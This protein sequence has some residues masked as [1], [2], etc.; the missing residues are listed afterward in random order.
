MKTD[1]IDRLLDK[2]LPP[3]GP[4]IWDAARAE[5]AA[6]K[7]AAARYERERALLKRAE[8]VLAG[9]TNPESHKLW[10]DIIEHFGP[11]AKSFSAKLRVA[12]DLK[13]EPAEPAKFGGGIE[14][15]AEPMKEKGTM[16]NE[17]TIT[18]PRARYERERAALRELAAVMQWSMD[19]H[20]STSEF[21]K[22]HGFDDRVSFRSQALT[23]HA[24][25]IAALAEPAEPK[26]PDEP[27]ER[28]MLAECMRRVAEAVGPTCY[29]LQF[30]R[31]EQVELC[32]DESNHR[33]WTSFSAAASA[34]LRGCASAGTELDEH[35]RPYGE[36]P[37]LTA[38]PKEPGLH[39]ASFF[40]NRDSAHLKEPAKEAPTDPTTCESPTASTISLAHTTDP[41]A[42]IRGIVKTVVEAWWRGDYGKGIPPA[43]DKANLVGQLTIALADAW[44]KGTP[45]PAAELTRLRAELEQFKQSIRDAHNG[46]DA[47]FRK[48]TGASEPESEL[49]ALAELLLEAKDCGSKELAILLANAAAEL[50][51]ANE[52]TEAWV[53]SAHE[54][55]RQLAAAR[56]EAERL[57]KK[58]AEDVKWAA[59]WGLQ[60]ALLREECGGTSNGNAGDD[61]I[62]VG[63]WIRDHRQSTPA[64]L[65]GLI[66]RLQDGRALASSPYN[67]RVLGAYTNGYTWFLVGADSAGGPYKHGISDSCISP[68]ALVAWID[69]NQPEP[70][71]P[72][73]PSVA[74]AIVTIEG[75]YSN[76]LGARTAEAW[77]VV[78][79][80]AMRAGKE[81]Q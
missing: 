52:K 65:D 70:P 23:R 67:Y 8:R 36:Q 64:P 76:L 75:D 38:E 37:V 55:A 25:T 16:T 21:A 11:T 6:L 74:E 31:S 46:Y 48:E 42:V 18:L 79:R 56:Q 1:N 34:V 9:H 41:A 59:H 19:G 26:E 5:L 44:P 49:E 24:A 7:E 30:A 27:D 77:N 78:K 80:A 54:N 3:I 71:P 4:G 57:T 35:G 2:D 68:A 12:A 43:N 15:T 17:P 45:E 33:R 58:S 14:S 47:D 81:G 60:L 72:A 39:T 13:A 62:I 28:P 50:A 51:A 29:R 53:K 32:D 40:A 22:R 63:K 66:E 20:E 69:A 73:E 10:N 61:A